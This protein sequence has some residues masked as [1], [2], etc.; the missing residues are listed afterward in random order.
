LTGK[1]PNTSKKIIPQAD[2]IGGEVIAPSSMEITQWLIA[3]SNGDQAALDQLIPLVHKELRQL[4]KRYMRQERG[5]ERRVVTLQTTAL[6]NEA[7][8]RLIDA[9]NV[10]WESRA[11]FFAISAQLMRRILVDYARSRNR[12]KHGRLAQRV[13]LEEAA[14][15]SVERAADLIALDDALDALAKIDE[16][17]SRVVVLRFFG[18][19]SVA[20]TAEVLKVSIGSVER[21]WRLA[22]L[23]LLGELGG[24][25]DDDA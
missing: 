18:G 1:N 12:V 2:L 19:L 21:D 15:F 14:V 13:E 9:S 11:H 10:K 20:E 6:V 24:E 5:R 16:R 22:K 8:L 3:W 7:Y 17:K 23:W 4:A 25:R